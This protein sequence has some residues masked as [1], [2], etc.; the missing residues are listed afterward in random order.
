MKAAIEKTDRVM[1]TLAIARD[2][3]PAGANFTGEADSAKNAAVQAV[4]DARWAYRRKQISRLRKADRDKF[5]PLAKYECYDD[6]WDDYAYGMIGKDRYEQLDKLWDERLEALTEYPDPDKYNDYADDYTA[7][8]DDI[9]KAVANMSTNDL[10]D[11]RKI[12]ELW[13]V[14]KKA[15]RVDLRDIRIPINQK[16]R[17]DIE[18]AVKKVQNCTKVRTIDADDIYKMAETVKDW[19]KGEIPRAAL[20]GTRVLI[21]LNAQTFAKSYTRNFMPT[22]TIAEFTITARQVYLTALY[23]GRC[24]APSKKYEWDMPKAARDILDAQDK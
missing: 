13:R 2:Q 12:E 4:R 8:L 17:G 11:Y 23:R 18:D 1:R 22:S 3:V 5:K 24:H 16:H 15:R 9:I 10:D 7:V 14:E 20:A 21:D 19:Y 6:L